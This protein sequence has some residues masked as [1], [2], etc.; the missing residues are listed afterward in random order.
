LLSE[1]TIVSEMC[2]RNVFLLLMLGIWELVRKNFIKQSSKKTHFLIKI[3]TLQ[4]SMFNESYNLISQLSLFC[5]WGQ[6]CSH[7]YDDGSVFESTFDL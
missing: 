4:M 5:I 6:V 1:S 2:S 3:L 7:S